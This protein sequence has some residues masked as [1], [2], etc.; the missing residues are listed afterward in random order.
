MGNAWMLKLKGVPQEA[1]LWRYQLTRKAC[2]V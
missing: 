2:S 1:A